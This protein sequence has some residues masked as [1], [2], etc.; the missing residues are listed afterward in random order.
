MMRGFYNGVS[1]IKTQSFGMDV[2]SNN[3]SNINNVGFKASI[4]EFKNLI[5]QNLVSAGSGPTSDQVG[6]GATK[7]TT[8][9]DMSNGSFQSTDNNFDLAIG[10]DG[11]F[12]VV[13]KTGKNYYT[14]TGTFDIDAAGNLVDTRGNLLLGTLAQLSALGHIGAENLSG[15]DRGNTQTLGDTC[16]LCALARSGRAEEND[17]GHRKN[18]S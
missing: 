2:W 4:P 1:G 15:R 3:I 8:A 9:L 6:L 10:G 7:Q 13:D 11:F 5:N 12:G 16:C 17:S 14:R 18:P